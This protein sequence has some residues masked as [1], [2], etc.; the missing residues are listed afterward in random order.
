[1]GDSGE[2]TPQRVELFALVQGFALAGDLRLG[3]LALLELVGELLVEVGEGRAAFVQ[4]RL[5]GR[6]SPGPSR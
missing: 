4:S 6:R 2:Q 5:A 3:A 1:M